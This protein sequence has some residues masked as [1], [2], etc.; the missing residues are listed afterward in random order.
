M[1]P[2]G[3]MWT[4]N[5]RYSKGLFVR[6]IRLTRVRGTYYLRLEDKFELVIRSKSIFAIE[7]HSTGIG[8]NEIVLMD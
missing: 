6:C 8:V 7:I 5:L 1:R 4:V 2:I 3:V